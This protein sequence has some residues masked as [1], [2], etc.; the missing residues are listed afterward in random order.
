MWGIGLA[1]DDKRIRNP[2][3]WQGKNLLGFALMAIR[4]QLI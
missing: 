4:E 1:H 3:E 2:L